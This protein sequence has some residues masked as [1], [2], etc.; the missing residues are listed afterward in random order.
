MLKKANN[1]TMR[2]M[3]SNFVACFTEAYKDNNAE[4]Q[5]VID[6]WVREVK[7]LN[8]TMF[9]RPDSIIKINELLFS[10]VEVRDFVFDMC[11]K[12]FSTYAYGENYDFVVSGLANGLSVDGPEPSK[13]IIPPELKQSMPV[14]VYRNNSILDW[15]KFNLNKIG[16][17]FKT[18]IEAF[19]H[20]NKLVISI[21]LVH[22]THSLNDE[23]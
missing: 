20:N 1:Q 23:E 16:F 15:V 8:V 6:N 17:R 9:L 7:M 12:Y 10:R 13:C 3:L 14:S 18:P 2:L 19:L 5:V 11:F 22:L 4:A 21:L